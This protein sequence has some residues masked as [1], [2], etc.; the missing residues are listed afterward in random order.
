MVKTEFAESFFVGERNQRGK[1]R[2]FVRCTYPA[3]DFF[4]GLYEGGQALE[5]S[6]IR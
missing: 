1:D 6:L 5:V 3:A 2:L 4:K